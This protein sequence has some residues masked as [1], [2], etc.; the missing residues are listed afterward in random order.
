MQ[1]KKII[2]LVLGIGF[3]IF[4]ITQPATV[5][6][7]LMQANSFGL[8]LS[9][10]SPT[11]LNL[12]FDE[13]YYT[14]NS[15]LGKLSW[16]LPTL[17][18][19][20]GYKITLTDTTNGTNY[21]FISNNGNENFFVFDNFDFIST[22]DYEFVIESFVE[23]S[24]ENKS[25][26]TASDS[27][28]LNN[29]ED[30]SIEEEEEETPPSTGGGGGGYSPP[31]TNTITLTDSSGNTSGT[32]T[33][34]NSVNLSHT[35][36]TV[37]QNL[38]VSTKINNWIEIK[39]VYPEGTQITNTKTDNFR[40]QILPA[41][42]L[43]NT[44]KYDQFSK[45]LVY[46]DTL[47]ENYSKEIEILI[48]LILINESNYLNLEDI[49][50][51]TIKKENNEDYFD[52]VKPVYYD[53][54]V[55]YWKP[56]NKYDIEDGLLKIYTDT[57]K[58]FGFRFPNEGEQFLNTLIEEDLDIEYSNETKKEE[59]LITKVTNFINNIQQENFKNFYKTIVGDREEEEFHAAAEKD[60]EIAK[61]KQ[62]TQ[63]LLETALVKFHTN[64]LSL[65]KEDNFIFL[66]EW[67]EI[68]VDYGPTGTKLFESDIPKMKFD[69][70]PAQAIQNKN[71]HPKISEIFVYPDNLRENYSQNVTIS[72]PTYIAAQNRD[73]RNKDIRVVYYDDKVGY[74][75]PY[76]EHRYYEEDSRIKIKSTNSVIF[77]FRFTD[78]AENNNEL[79]I[80]HSSAEMGVFPAF[81]FSTI[82]TSKTVGNG[83]VI[84]YP[85]FLDNMISVFGSFRNIW[86]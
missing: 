83:S 33:T 37:T 76:K 58:I 65:E 35:G 3:N 73:I 38:E 2:S 27:L 57:S 17:A 70:Y 46:P 19:A 28:I 11:P 64:S 62:K 63:D 20:H 45:L 81:D 53:P 80:F 22:H 51:Q 86:R 52:N 30:L 77:G 5:V 49:K 47:R 72:V 71:V 85:T 1:A 44:E 79:D 7:L 6:S 68:T 18:G 23:D 56:Y 39:V 60:I 41:K 10:V 82:P 66:R 26:S 50:S 31:P 55:K 29:L 67:F 24:G 42:V 32:I 48:P 40:S 59:K 25:Y 8:N 84:N 78:K 69:I 54:I 16:E 14:N 15:G 43:D 4:L 21:V 34:S 13:D 9:I 61:L 74:W 12:E 75:K 36:G